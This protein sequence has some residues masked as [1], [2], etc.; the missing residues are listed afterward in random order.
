M[1]EGYVDS[2]HDEE[3]GVPQDPE[4]P[5]DDEDACSPA[6]IFRA[7]TEDLGDTQSRQ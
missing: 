1:P 6:D 2:D 3:G 7:R 4:E 5:D